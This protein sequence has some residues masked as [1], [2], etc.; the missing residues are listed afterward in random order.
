MPLTSKYNFWEVGNA[1]PWII[2]ENLIAERCTLMFEWELCE[3]RCVA[4]AKSVS[5]TGGNAWME[6]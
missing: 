2:E 6:W 1:M 4:Y 5:S 3:A